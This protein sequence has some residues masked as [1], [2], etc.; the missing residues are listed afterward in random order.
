MVANYLKEI[1]ASLHPYEEVETYLNPNVWEVSYYNP[2][3]IA[4]VQSHGYSFQR[5]MH[6]ATLDTLLNR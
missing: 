5:K 3:D 6:F 2:D 4:R 1:G